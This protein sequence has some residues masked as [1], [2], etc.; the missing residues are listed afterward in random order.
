MNEEDSVLCEGCK[1]RTQLITAM[2]VVRFPQVLP[3]VLQRVRM[4]PSGLE[5]S[6]IKIQ[7]PIDGLDLSQFEVGLTCSP[8]VYDLIAVIHHSGRSLSRGHYVAYARNPVTGGWVKYD[9]TSVKEV[10]ELTA[11]QDEGAY[12][13]FY[14]R[15]Y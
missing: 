3:I 5:K 10:S 1:G 11:V 6:H 12:M 2:Q 13:L 8:A 9:D 4:L 7:Y 15:R 14:R